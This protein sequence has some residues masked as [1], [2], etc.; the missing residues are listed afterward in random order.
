MKLNRYLTFLLIV[1]LLGTTLAMPA[2]AQNAPDI[3]VPID[4]MKVVRVGAPIDRVVLGT[5]GVVRAN[6]VTGQQIMLFGLQPGSTTMHVWTEAGLRKFN[7]SAASLSGDNVEE[8]SESLLRNLG[9]VSDEGTE[10]RV[11][12]P[13]YREVSEFEQYISQFLQDEGRVVMSDQA[14]GKVFAVGPPELLD[15]IENL[16]SEIDVPS[17]QEMYTRKI[18]VINRPVTQLDTKVQNLLSEDGSVTIDEETNSI[19]LVDHVNNVKKIENYIQSIDVQTE[20]QV[21]VTA[22][23]V[24]M[25]DDAQRN[26]GIEWEAVGSVDGEPINIDFLPGS[27][28]SQGFEGEINRGGFSGNGI[29][30]QIEA[31]ESKG[32]AKLISSPNIVTRNQQQ[33]SLQIVDEQS[34]VSACDVTFDDDGNP[35]SVTPQVEQIEGGITLNVTPSIGKNQEVV[36]LDLVP[37]LSEV[38]GLQNDEGITQGSGASEC[39]FFT[40]NKNIRTADL[41]VA[42]EN[43]KTLVIGGMKEIED[44]ESQDQI[45]FFGS[46]PVLGGAFSNS[47]NIDDS[48]EITIFLTVEVMSVGTSNQSTTSGDTINTSDSLPSNNSDQD[49]STASSSTDV[50]LD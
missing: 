43:G 4:G 37:E 46:I 21:R 22:R 7:L 29:R 1:S 35:V 34:Y 42:I 10:L 15:R 49:N 47:S 17:G 20:H 3:E 24:E 38:T 9:E 41:N 48:T 31:L 23:F 27:L 2:E 5:S 40:P 28:V 26:L 19:L 18:N 33:A 16:L 14:A 36:Q 32:E 13:E 39:T 8:Q 25:T 12:V 30:A 45:P 6:V 11:F 44:R 50:L